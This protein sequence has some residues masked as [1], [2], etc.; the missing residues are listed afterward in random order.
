MPTTTR[1]T[2]GSLLSPGG[3]LFKIPRQIRDEIYRLLVKGRY[4]IIHESPPSD[5]KSTEPSATA[6]LAILRVSKA[7]S[8]EALRIMYQESMFHYVLEFDHLRSYGNPRLV[9]AVLPHLTPAIDHMIDHMMNIKISMLGDFHAEDAAHI[10]HAI[11]VNHIWTKVERDTLQIQVHGPYQ[12]MLIFHTLQ[13]IGIVPN[14]RTVI[15]IVQCIGRKNNWKYEDIE[16]IIGTGLGPPV[17]GYM[18]DPTSSTRWYYLRFH[19]RQHSTG[20]LG[21]T[22]K[23]L[24]K[25]TA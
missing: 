12:R 8:H 17:R 10:R 1:V 21:Q 7:I 25:N 18:H 9:Q 3:T 23:A 11:F 4:L 15:V 13:G 14:V 6:Y 2:T 5:I 24:S 20:V 16:N 19:P 22:A